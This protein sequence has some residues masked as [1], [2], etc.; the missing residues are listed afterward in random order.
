MQRDKLK[1]GLKWIAIVFSIPSFVF[2][3]AGLAVW[4]ELLKVAQDYIRPMIAIQLF[5]YGVIWFL[6]VFVIYRLGR[7]YISLWDAP[8]LS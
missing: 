4:G 5:F 8:N 1:L 3:L 7:S 6:I 2:T